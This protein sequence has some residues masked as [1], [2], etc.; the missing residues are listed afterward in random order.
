MLTEV[1]LLM[2]GF[3]IGVF[4]EHFKHMVRGIWKRQWGE[5]WQGMKAHFFKH[6]APLVIIIA[7]L[8]LW[9]NWHDQ[10]QQQLMTEEITASVITKLD[11]RDSEVI[12]RLDRIIELLEVSNAE[13]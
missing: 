1:V 5:V 4:D 12:E 7:L 10:R 9:A 2:V 8:L 11:Q 13:R 6:Y 3:L